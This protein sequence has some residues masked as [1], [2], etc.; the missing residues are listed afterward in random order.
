MDDVLARECAELF[1]IR[2]GYTDLPPV[3][4]STQWVPEFMDT[5]VAERRRMLRRRAIAVC[6][7]AR[8]ADAVSV[9]FAYDSTFPLP[10]PATEN[11]PRAKTGRVVEV[12]A[13]GSLALVHQDVF[14]PETSEGCH[15]GQC[16]PVAHADE[17][18]AP[19]GAR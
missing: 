17:P 1:I 10:K 16:R 9:I 4:D 2:N 12:G 14:L 6:D 8:R 3:P 13:D 7:F 18:V 15:D 11:E 19:N 5:G